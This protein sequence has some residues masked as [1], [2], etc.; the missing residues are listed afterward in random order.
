MRPG[1]SLSAFCLANYV[2]GHILLLYI[3]EYNSLRYYSISNIEVKTAPAFL[4]LLY[5]HYI[6][7]DKNIRTLHLY[8]L[9][10]NK[11][12]GATIP[13]NFAADDAIPSPTFLKIKVKNHLLQIRNLQL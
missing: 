2:A 6:Y 10:S 12:N 5:R 7:V 1:A 8:V 11:E 4:N 3:K 9:T 13:P